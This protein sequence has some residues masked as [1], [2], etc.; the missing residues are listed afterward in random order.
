V[1]FFF[2]AVFPFVV[3]KDAYTVSFNAF[4]G[5]ILGDSFRVCGVFPVNSVIV[6]DAG[7]GEKLVVAYLFLLM[8]VGV[9]FLDKHNV[10]FLCAEPHF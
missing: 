9:C 7:G 8:V 10:D 3:Y 6:G 4:F 2:D 5:C 1:V